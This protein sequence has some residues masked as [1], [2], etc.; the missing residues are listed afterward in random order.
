MNFTTMIIMR[1]IFHIILLVLMTLGFLGKFLLDQPNP[2]TVNE[3]SIQVVKG[4]I[5][6]PAQLV[7]TKLWLTEI[8]K[9]D[10]HLNWI[11]GLALVAPGRP[12]R[13]KGCLAALAAML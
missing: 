6:D 3:I 8:T 10:C 12:G 9:Q 2:M 7:K 11:L 13:Q 1:H 5:G 4:M